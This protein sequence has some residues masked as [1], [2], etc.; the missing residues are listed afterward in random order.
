MNL[1]TA[2]KQWQDRPADE[3]FESIEE[4]RSATFHYATQAR[5]AITPFKDIRV[6]KVDD[7]LNLV[8]RAGNAARLTNFAFGQLSALAGAWP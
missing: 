5:E 7:D 6:E 3:R 4:M 1:F 8:G 2:S